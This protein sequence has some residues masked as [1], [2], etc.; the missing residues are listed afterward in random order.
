MNH[1]D[2]KNTENKVL[3]YC[4]RHKM[5]QTGDRVVLGVSGGADSICLLFV[6]LAL[7]EQLG[8]HLHVVHVNHGLRSDAAEDAAYVE[9]LCKVRNI[10]FGL[11]EIRLEEMARQWGASC[12]EAGRIAR[13]QAF[14]EACEKWQ[15]TKIAVAHNSNDRAE[16]MLFHLFRGTGLRGMAGILPVRDCIV[17]PLL[18]LRR[19]EIEAYLQDRG[20]GF[21][22]DST[23]DTDDFTRNRIRHH[24]LPYVQ[25]NI[26]EA[27]ISNMCR[28]G[29]I[30]AEE[31]AYLEEQTSKALAACVTAHS[32]HVAE[33]PEEIR[34]VIEAD[35]FQ[36]QH[37]VVVIGVLRLRRIAFQ[38]MI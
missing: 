10:P 11:V 38:F 17:R 9:S 25:Q 7:Q 4:R 16:T 2:V 3:S 23:N 26:A 6:L 13:Y 22:S 33:N 30:F 34:Y 35:S 21:R 37:M 19:E 24:I 29:D 32:S 28:A 8:I 18:C 1:T 5:F 31:E 12:E 14:E 27:V 20:I 36:Q 15:C